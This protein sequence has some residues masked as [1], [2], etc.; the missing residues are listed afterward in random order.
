MVEEIEVSADHARIALFQRREWKGCRI[1]T[2][3]YGAVRRD[4]KRFTHRP[5][6]IYFDA[7]EAEE[8]R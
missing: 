3:N 2:Q 7:L 5:G 4:W 6:S 1:L 8:L